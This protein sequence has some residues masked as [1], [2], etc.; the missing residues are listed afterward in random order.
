MKYLYCALAFSF[1]SFGTHAQV[2]IGTTDP[3][4]TLDIQI[5]NTGSPSNTDGLLIPRFDAVPATD[6]TD[7]QHSMLMYLTST[8]GSYSPG[9][10][11]WDKDKGLNGQWV[12]MGRDWKIDGNEDVVSGTHFIGTTIAEEVDFRVNNKLVGRL[13]EQ[14]QFELMSDDKTV[15]IGFEA[16]E[17]YDPAGTTAEQNVYIGYQAAKASTSGRDNVAVG[18]FSMTSNTTGNF[19]VGVGD[20]TMENNTTGDD[21]TALGNDVLRSNTTGNGNTGI[22]RDALR[23]NQTANNNT[24]VGLNALDSARSDDNTA[25]GYDAGES[26][27]SGTGNTMLGSGTDV[28]NAAISNSVAIGMGATVA[29]SNQ[30]CY[31]SITEIDQG[32]AVVVNASD[33]RF[34]YN[35]QENVSGLEFIQAL[36]PVTYN[37]DVEKYNQ[38]RKSPSTTKN[39]S[40]VESGFIAQEIEVAMQ[41]TGYNFNGLVIPSDTSKDN[42]KV[43]YATFVVPLVKAVQEQQEEIE[44][45]KEEIEELKKVK[46][47]VA[48]LKALM[49]EM[50]ASKK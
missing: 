37:F 12:P 15:L 32:N 28:S 39:S 6:P 23:S 29:K 27:V 16:G 22:G 20:E 41:K 17:N 19:N 26:I 10:H 18:A 2:G 3:K 38:F 11:Y 24:A 44:T 34:K 33:G 1:L 47:E 31:G 43:S 21:N 14:G 35:V 7:D 46:D 36:R 5:P 9:F 45:L 30:L 40:V 48:Q 25:V 50:S 4:S 49:T 42:Y 8:S 13:T